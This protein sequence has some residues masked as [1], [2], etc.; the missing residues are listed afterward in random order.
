MSGILASI[1]SVF[2]KKYYADNQSFLH[3]Y[4]FRQI[5]FVT[6]NI[7]I[8]I[9]YPIN[10]KES[11]VLSYLGNFVPS[12]SEIGILTNCVNVYDKVSNFVRATNS[13]VH[14]VQRARSDW[15]KVRYNIEQIYENIE[16]LKQIDPYDMDTWQSGLDNFSFSLKSRKSKAIRAFE[17]LE[18]H[19]LGASETYLKK[20]QSLDD[21]K[22]EVSIKRDAIKSIYSNPSYAF[23]LSE[24]SDVIR[25][26][27]R[28]TIS[29][30]RS[31]QS[32]DL[33]ILQTSS[34]QEERENAQSHMVELEKN[35]QELE[36]TLTLDQQQEKTDSIID[37]SSN[38]IAINLTEIKICN[39]RIY[40]MNRASGDLV[41]AFY[42]LLGHNVNSLISDIDISLPDIPIDPSN[43]NPND[44]DKVAAPV[45]P[46]FPAMEA[47]IAKK[48]VSNHDILNLY[49][50]ASFLALKQ[51][52][53]KR[54]ILAMKVN[55]FAFMV[56]MEAMRRNR[57]EVT[58]I[59]FAHHCRMIQIA[60]ED[61]H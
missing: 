15:D 20:I 59:A 43:F 19:T 36:E 16:Y 24:A 23:E 22:S 41:A 2:L 11:K 1:T 40:E 42:R 54:D 45:T 47:V 21:Y 9:V 6:L 18:A 8:L 25:S 50:A 17:M 4:H 37:Q 30:L 14:C 32:A 55:T 29:Q 48:N 57:S 27:R 38:L 58:A 31:M 35:I 34:N 52:C 28:N 49:N 12:L 10:A 39:Q 33:L 26:Y 61:L 56:S 46:I 7:S 60:M 44:P 13:L 51:E 5:L 53:L 3:I